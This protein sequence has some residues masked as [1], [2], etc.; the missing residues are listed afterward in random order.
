[1]W[2]SV[3][4]NPVSQDLAF[5]TK[6]SLLVSIIATHES[7]R[8]AIPT[9]R[10]CLFVAHRILEC[11]WRFTKGHPNKDCDGCSSTN[12]GGMYWGLNGGYRHPRHVFVPIYE[13]AHL[14]DICTINAIPRAG[15]SSSLGMQRHRRASARGDLRGHRSLLGSRHRD[16]RFFGS[17]RTHN[18]RRDGEE[19]A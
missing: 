2:E 16:F 14:G 9:N 13:R 7:P 8:Y 12:A 11:N 19:A 3:D 6:S 10:V 15:S 1:M 5:G 4:E 18:C 17:P